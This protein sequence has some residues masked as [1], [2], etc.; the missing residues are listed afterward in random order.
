MAVSGTVQCGWRAEFDKD[1]GQELIRKGSGE[2]GM[3]QKHM[4]LA[5][6]ACLGTFMSMT[7]WAGPLKDNLVIE[8][9]TDSRGFAPTLHGNPSEYFYATTIP[10]NTAFADTLPI[11]FDLSDTDNHPGDSYTVTLTA[12]GQVAF[13]IS[14]DVPSFA[15]TEP[16]TAKHYAYIN[17]SALAPGD[18][19]A[20]VQINAKLAGNIDLTH[21]T[22]H[23]HIH[24]TGGPNAA[25]CYVTDSSGLDLSDCSGQLTPTGGEF[26]VVSNQKKITAT[27]PGQFYYNF[28]WTNDTGGDVTFASIGL[29]GT[30]VVP[31]GTNSVHVLIYD[32]AGFTANFDDVNQSGIPCGNV[33]IACKSPITVPAGQTLWL[34]WHVAY[35]W[36][37]QPL[38]SDIPA[39]GTANCGVGS[40]HGTIAMSAV[41]SNADGSVTL[42]C[43]PVGA[44]G[45]NIR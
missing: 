41:L 29:S 1:S 3:S 20:N 45:Q 13:A 28:V 39:A 38:L 12:V 15:M 11:Q 33:G 42:S 2:K 16:A 8:G 21:S 5:V 31:A 43:G 37:G 17:T 30:N 9:Q 36:L 18:Y 35:Q 34:T 32:A 25:T 14:F 24:V 27:N 6:A 4:F 22:L 40:T 23:L 44:N 10:A 19:H 26:R 7:G